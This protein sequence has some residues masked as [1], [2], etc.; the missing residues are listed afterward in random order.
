MCSTRTPL[1]ISL[2]LAVFSTLLSAP[3]ATAEDARHDVDHQAYE[4]AVQKAIEFLRVKGQAADGSFSSAAGPG[5]TAIVATGILRNG[6][7]A[8]DPLVVKSLKYLT[9]FIQP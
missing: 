9:G 5:V 1:G 7:T 4:R 3:R 8:D 6:R 2:A